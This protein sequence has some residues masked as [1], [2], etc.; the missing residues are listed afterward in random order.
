MNWE[1]LRRLSEEVPPDFSERWEE[2]ANLAECI[3]GYLE[4]CVKRGSSTLF[5]RGASCAAFGLGHS[6]LTDSVAFLRW[7][8]SR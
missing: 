7:R 5:L 2:A 6:S 4:L 1:V 8:H 3:V